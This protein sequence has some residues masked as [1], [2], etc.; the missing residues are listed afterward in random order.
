MAQRGAE[1]SKVSGEAETASRENVQHQ[2]RTHNST[3]QHT[4]PRGEGQTVPKENRDTFNWGE[5]HVLYSIE[6]H[7]DD[8]SK[9]SRDT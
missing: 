9:K 7:S 2:R 5:I 8:C 6:E 4:A 1:A 3:G